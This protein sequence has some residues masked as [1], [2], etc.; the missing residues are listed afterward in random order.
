MLWKVC[1]A[2]AGVG[3]AATLVG[4]SGD[5]RRFA[6]SYLFAFF[7]FLTIS[8]GSMFFVLLQHLTAASW[9][10]TVRRTAEFLASGIPI[11]AL[12]F[13][14][15]GLSAKELYPWLHTS[16]GAEHS[17]AEHSKAHDPSAATEEHEA[18]EAG[19]GAREEGKPNEHAAAAP[20]GA[21]SGSHGPEHAAHAKLLQE[22]KPFLNLPRFAIAAAIYLIIW[23]LLTQ[24]FFRKSV[25][26]DTTKDPQNTVKM[27]RWAPVATFLLGLSVTFAGFDWLMSLEPTWYSTIYG[28]YIFASS[29]VASLATLILL[30]MGLRQIA[31][32][33]TAINTEHYHDL[34][35]LLFGFL[36]FWAYIGFSQLLLIWYA[37]IP[38]ETTYYHSRWDSGGWRAASRFLL[39]GKFVVPFLFLLSRNIKRRLELLTV[40]AGWLI[41]MHVFDMYWFVLPYYKAHHFSFHLLDVSCLLLVGGLYFA[42]IFFRMKRHALVPI[43]DPRLMRSLNFHN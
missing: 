23:T 24:W 13:V 8:I 15:I 2:I 34:G 39:V 17:G 4:Y 16:H 5:H 26:Q 11:F 12:L 38:E 41:F 40:G 10:V 20:H 1:L 29:M 19:K 7:A 22:K 35:K 30:T 31:G 37:G 9:S 32:L 42:V 36:V 14:P 3:L 33:E 25:T 28:V 27:E 18:L 43:G 6:F 21:H